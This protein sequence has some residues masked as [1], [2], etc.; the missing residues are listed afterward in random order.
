MS[1]GLANNFNKEEKNNLLGFPIPSFNDALL[2]GNIF[3]APIKFQYDLFSVRF[4]NTEKVEEKEEKQGGQT[5]YSQPFEPLKK[6]GV[7]VFYNIH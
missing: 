4:N 7:A 5:D 2:Y 3:T 1:E 6:V